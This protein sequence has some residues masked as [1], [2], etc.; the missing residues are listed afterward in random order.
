MSSINWVDKYEFIKYVFPSERLPEWFKC[1]L[2]NDAFVAFYPLFTGRV[3]EGLLRLNV[4]E[5]YIFWFAYYPVCKGNN[6]SGESGVARKISRFRL[7]SWTSS[8][9]GGNS[10]S[11]LSGK[12]ESN[13][14]IRLL[15]AYLRTFVPKG[16]VGSCQ[17]PYRSSLLHYT[18]SLYDGPALV[19]A[20]FLVHTLV[21]FWMVDNDFSPLSLDICRSYGL[22][23]PFRAVLRESPPTPRLGDVLNLLVMYLNCGLIN[24]NGKNVP[25]AFAESPAKNT[26]NFS[27]GSWNLI[28]QRPLYRFLLR[29]F[30]FCPMGA[31]IKNTSQVLSVWITYLMPW[32]IG[33]EDFAEFE[34]T[35]DKNDN[36]EKVEG[37]AV[38]TPIWESYVANNYL[39]YSSLVVHFLGFAHKFLHTN[40]D[41]VV[42]LVS[43]VLNTLT[44]SQ[45]LTDFL[46]KV[47][48]AYHTKQSG[49]LSSC[50]DNAQ[51][52]IPSIRE[53][54]QDWEDGL[55]ESDADGS[56]LH[57]NW[58]RDLKLFSNDEDGAAK[59]LQ[60]FILRAEHEL[61]VRSGDVQYLNAVK[62]QM[63]TLFSGQIAT[64]YTQHPATPL[65][66]QHQHD[67]PEVFTPKHPASKYRG[68][69]MTRPISDNEVAWLA[70]LLIRLSNW[71][72][73]ILGFDSNT[74]STGLT[75]VDVPHE[76]TV[77]I[78]GAKE[79]FFMLISFIG[80]CLF[81]FAR[82]VV[83]LMRRWGMK[84][85]LRVLASK[86]VV[87]ALF[88][89]GFAY[90]IKKAFWSSSC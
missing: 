24:N 22:V 87:M 56:F 42:Q 58:N 15:Y 47:D 75:F 43:K 66:F 38:Y 4:F 11:K 44:S 86:K 17:Q 62:S 63:N 36:K 18:E 61:Q 32:K 82:T 89:Y 64:S 78:G 73:D 26:G 13:L 10:S 49:P 77:N 29:S 23:F 59:L 35:S 5:Y 80:S 90:F 83:K 76:E 9:V 27:A 79:A 70:K 50:G 8:L 67:R 65:N 72:N 55:C 84:I 3:N 71:L 46:R 60:L 54:L 51:K 81:I 2:D 53:Q 45:E 7:E 14:Y 37:D 19:Q 25:I 88:V 39:F 74:E 1:V 12:K 28:T 52:Y 40:V 34:T 68:D 16:G 85:N 30:L 20:E 57:E 33:V 31:S 48:S 21:N 41:A 69:S 6:E